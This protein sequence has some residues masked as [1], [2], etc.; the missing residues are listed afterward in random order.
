[1]IIKEQNQLT[2]QPKKMKLLSS[3]FVAILLLTSCQNGEEKAEQK[4][5]EQQKSEQ[6]QTQQKQPESNKTDQTKKWVLDE[7]S[8]SIHWTGYKTTGKVAV[9]GVF[10]NFKIRG[11]KPSSDLKSAIKNALAEIN[12]Y[13]I[14]SDNEDR[15]KKLIV[16]LFKNMTD[17][18]KIYARIERLGEDNQS[19]MMSIKMN[20]HKKTVPV[21]VV[22]DEKN[23]KVTI[24]GRIDLIKDFEAGKAFEQFHKACFKKHKGKDG[25]SKTWTEVA[26]S[27][28]LIFTKK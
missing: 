12:V 22:I 6:Q 19:A 24:S 15:D 17:T 21:K 7:D 9:K 8:S 26:V 25:V 23:G 2:K 1:M 4:Q 14:F 3:L 27:A 20:A 18:P 13:S 28:E 11:I 16:K 5:T 10:Q